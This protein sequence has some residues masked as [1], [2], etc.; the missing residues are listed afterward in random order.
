MAPA[1]LVLS[2]VIILYPVIVYFSLGHFEPRPIAIVLIGLALVRL[3]IDGRR[4]YFSAGMAQAAL[5]AAALLLVGISATALNSA[6]LLQ[7]YP[8]YLNFMLFA[9]FL[10][11]LLH[12]PSIV[13]Q[14]A[15]PREPEF[16]EAAVIYTRRVTMVWCGFFA[17][18][19]TV[20]LYTIIE[21]DLK[22]WAI[23]NGFI[24]YCLIGLLFVGEIFARR[25]AKRAAAP[26][27]GGESWVE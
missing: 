21:T 7:Y 15:R 17:F 24:S 23:Y 19:G 4:S 10:F 2:A 18:N 11:S 26:G 12:P 9:L 13:E 16:P 5:V 6:V 3:L 14:I 20:A 8:V 27:R 1:K 25:I 22:I